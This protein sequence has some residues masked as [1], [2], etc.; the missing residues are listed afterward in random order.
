MAVPGQLLAVRE[1]AGDLALDPVRVHLVAGKLLEE[2]RTR[3]VD[4]VHAQ[5]LDLALVTTDFVDRLA[6]D[7]A[8]LLDLA[9]READSH[10]LGGDLGTDL[11]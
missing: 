3:H 2:M 10:Q 8:Q 11:E 7:V 1:A 5:V 9:R 6:N 4:L